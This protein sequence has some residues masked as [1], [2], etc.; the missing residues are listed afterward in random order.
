M[1]PT[2]IAAGRFPP[3]VAHYTLGYA[4]LK[5]DKAVAAIPELKAA[6]ALLG[7]ERQ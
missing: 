5:Q 4:Y 2:P 1:L 6:A 3:G 7:E